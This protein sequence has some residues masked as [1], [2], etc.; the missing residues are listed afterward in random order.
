MIFAGG[1]HEIIRL[2]LL[3]DEPH[4]LH[5]VFGIAPVA[6]GIEVAEIELV[7]QAIYDASH[8]YCDFSGYESL[9]ATLTL[10]IEENAIHSIHSVAL[11]IVLRNPEAVDF[12]A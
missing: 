1:N 8:C 7:L 2:G 4:T 3:H 6:V 10:V 9:T 11:A 5:I 12:S